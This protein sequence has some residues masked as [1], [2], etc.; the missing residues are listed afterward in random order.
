MITIS[1]LMEKQLPPT[2]GH[3]ASML[4]DILAGRKTEIDALN[5]AISRYAKELGIRDSLQR[6]SLRSDK[7]QREAGEP[8]SRP[9]VESRNLPIF[10]LFLQEKKA[11]SSINDNN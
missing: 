3:R 9:K 4:Q 10:S 8:G 7:V 11:F 6:S 2:K 1:Y 5:G